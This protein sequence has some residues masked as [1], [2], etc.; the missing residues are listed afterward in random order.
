MSSLD[1]VVFSDGRVEQRMYSGSSCYRSPVVASRLVIYI[2]RT[3]SEQRTISISPFNGAQSAL[4]NAT[5][6]VARR[7]QFR[8]TVAAGYFNAS[9][10]VYVCLWGIDSSRDT[11]I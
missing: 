8:P 4:T 1:D 7:A 3:F 9:V 10:F 6:Y 5:I 2:E 11:V